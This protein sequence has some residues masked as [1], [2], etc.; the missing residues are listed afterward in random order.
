MRLLKPVYDGS[1]KVYICDIKDAESFTYVSDV[2]GDPLSWT[3]SPSSFYE[4]TLPRC[5]TTILSQTQGWFSKPLAEDWLIQHLTYSI[6]TESIE[7]GFDGSATY[8]PQRLHISKDAFVIEFKL[9]D[10]KVAEKVCIEFQEE[11]PVVEQPVEQQ[12]VASNEV[13]RQ[14]MKNKV[15]QA[16]QRA[17]RA[18]FKA[19]ELMHSYVEKYGMDADWEDWDEED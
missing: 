7:N 1:K 15:L 4:E 18:L 3:K 17:A 2:Y 14:E 16:R 6:P 19:E 11:A 8:T 13:I 10:T 5:V 12:H 9:T